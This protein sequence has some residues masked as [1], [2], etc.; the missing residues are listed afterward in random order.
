M[1]WLQGE[2]HSRARAVEQACG[3]AGLTRGPSRLGV[4]RLPGSNQH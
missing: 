3:G 1:H 4:E 2:T